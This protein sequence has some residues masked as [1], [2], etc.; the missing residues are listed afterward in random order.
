[1]GFHPPMLPPVSTT[2]PGGKIITGMGSGAG[3]AGGVGGPGCGNARSEG[4][5]T[6]CLSPEHT[7]NED[8]P[9]NYLHPPMSLSGVVPDDDS[10]FSAYLQ[11]PMT[12]QEDSPNGSAIVV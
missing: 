1:L 4:K 3:G 2:S 9:M 7:G 6:E 11:P 12:L 5:S 10:L 8:S